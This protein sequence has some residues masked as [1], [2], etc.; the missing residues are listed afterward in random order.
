MFDNFV[1]TKPVVPVSTTSFSGL[2][3]YVKLERVD[4]EVLF[5]G[6][7]AKNRDFIVPVHLPLNE[8]RLRFEIFSD[9]PAD[10][11]VFGE[12]QL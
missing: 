12:I 4:G 8:D 2:R 1:S 6:E 7:V 11:I 5:L 9:S 10:Q 3:T